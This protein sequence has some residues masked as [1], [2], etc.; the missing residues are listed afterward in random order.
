M[1]HPRRK[2]GGEAHPLSDWS[3]CRMLVA[4]LL[5]YSVLRSQLTSTF[6][7]T[8]VRAVRPGVPGPLVPFE[9]PAAPLGS[10]SPVRNRSSSSRVGRSPVGAMAIEDHRGESAAVTCTSP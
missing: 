5:R 3:A 9:G 2:D 7:L 4:S 6:L 10:A 8:S 1:R